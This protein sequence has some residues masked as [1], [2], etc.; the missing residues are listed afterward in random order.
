M[1]VNRSMARLA[2][3]LNEVEK[4][5]ALAEAREEAGKQQPLVGVEAV[6]VKREDSLAS[7]KELSIPLILV[8]AGN[9]ALSKREVC[10]I[11]LEYSIMLFYVL[12]SISSGSFA[13]I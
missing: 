2:K 12:I 7:L 11:L 8:Q 10:T 4:L 1:I 9:L 6:I 13:L 3:N 5:L